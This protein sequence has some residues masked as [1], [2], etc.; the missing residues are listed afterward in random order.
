MVLVFSSET[1][2]AL[3]GIPCAAPPD[4]RARVGERAF[5]HK[6][7]AQSSRCKASQVPKVSVKV[8]DALGL[9]GAAARVAEPRAANAQKV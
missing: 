7:I 2:I 4:G 1:F 5:F 9:N 3:K 8:A 6:S